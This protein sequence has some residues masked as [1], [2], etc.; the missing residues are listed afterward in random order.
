MVVAAVALYN[1]INQKTRSGDAFRRVFW[2][3]HDLKNVHKV[4]ANDGDEVGRVV[5]VGGFDDVD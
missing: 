4:V 2:D 3:T 5:C 1:K